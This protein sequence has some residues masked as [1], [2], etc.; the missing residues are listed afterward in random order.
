MRNPLQHSRRSAPYG[1]DL[2]NNKVRKLSSGTVSTVAGTGK[3]FLD[4]PGASAQLN[5]PTDVCT[6]AAGNI[7]VAD[8]GNNCVRK[9]SLVK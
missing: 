7:Y 8:L 4:G 9:I 2:N 5:Q 6:D 1:A 3:G